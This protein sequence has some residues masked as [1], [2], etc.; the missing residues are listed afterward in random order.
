MVELVGRGYGPILHVLEA[1]A[2][3]V[4]ERLLELDLAMAWIAA[5]TVAGM[6]DA[7]R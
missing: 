1:S 5:E 3:S 6:R 7:I 4:D 2:E